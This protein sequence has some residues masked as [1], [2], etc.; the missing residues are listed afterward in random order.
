MKYRHELNYQY[1]EDLN[2]Y[3]YPPKQVRK[4]NLDRE[5]VY[6][7]HRHAFR[8]FV[9]QA[10]IWLGAPG[11]KSRYGLKIVGKKNRDLLKRA[12]ETGAITICN[13]IHKNDYKL[14][15][16][17]LPTRKST[18][19]VPK[20][21]HL[22][23]KGRY[24]RK[25]GS[26]PVPS[27][28][29]EAMKA[30]EVATDVC[31]V[32]GNWLHIFPEVSMFPYYQDLRPFNDEAFKIAVRNNRPIFPLAFSYRP[33]KNKRNKKPLLTL[34]FGEP[35]SPDLHLPLEDAVIDLSLKCHIAVKKLME[36]NTPE[37]KENK[38]A[39]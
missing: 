7:S 29:K 37:I 9:K 17:A 34:S 30:M 3:M 35:I 22:S 4:D 39:Q 16:S 19:L 25:L 20:E 15:K 36:N 8:R 18:I 14:I 23:R 5:Y 33:R 38:K 6:L 28:N 24:L 2:S 27:G 13:H 1:P 26:I 12:M 31:L 10:N 21:V 11:L 32:T